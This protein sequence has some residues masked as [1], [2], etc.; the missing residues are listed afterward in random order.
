MKISGKEF[1]IIYIHV[2]DINII[3]TPEEFPKAINLLQKQFE[4]KDI[5]KTKLCLDL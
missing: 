4:I 1:D 3:G 5:E 2:D